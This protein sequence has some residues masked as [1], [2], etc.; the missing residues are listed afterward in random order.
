M[1]MWDEGY[2]HGLRPHL[3]VYHFN[4]TCTNNHAPPSREGTLLLQLST[5]HLDGKYKGKQFFWSKTCPHNYAP[6]AGGIYFCVCFLFKSFFHS[7]PVTAV[8]GFLEGLMNF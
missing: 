5:P 8:S 2:H 7:S 6:L 1:L 3:V 4:C